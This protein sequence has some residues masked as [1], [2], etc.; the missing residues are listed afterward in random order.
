AARLGDRDDPGPILVSARLH[1]D[2]IVERLQV[3][4][5][6]HRRIMQRR[7]I[8]EHHQLDALQAED[9]IGLR[10][11]PIVA[12][13]HAGNS[14]KGTPDAEAQVARLEIALLQVLESPPWLVLM[15][16][17]QMNLAVLADDLARLI[18]DDRGVEP[19][20][21]LAVLDQLRVAEVEA[22]AELDGSLE[23]RSRLRSRHLALEV[24]IDLRLIAH[25]P[26]RE[27]RR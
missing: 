14:P 2:L 6:W 10:P 7:V 8:A 9:A 19:A 24:G 13:R 25:V 3:I 17:R 23:Q 27:E 5:L 1:H 22:D 4:V 12:Q 18:D 21:A 26:A 15:V 20:R 16:S 11:A